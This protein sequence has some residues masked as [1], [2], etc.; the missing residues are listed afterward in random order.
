MRFFFAFL[1]F[2]LAFPLFATPQSF[3]DTSTLNKL[4]AKNVQERLNPIPSFP[5]QMTKVEIERPSWSSDFIHLHYKGSPNLHVCVSATPAVSA[6]GEEQPAISAPNHSRAFYGDYYH[7]VDLDNKGQ[8]V[9]TFTMFTAAGK[10][11]TVSQVGQT[12]FH[13]DVVDVSGKNTGV[14]RSP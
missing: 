10:L 12:R 2:S 5:V 9:V 8:G 6:S 4:A 13:L 14:F 7:C 1:V 3:S 11:L